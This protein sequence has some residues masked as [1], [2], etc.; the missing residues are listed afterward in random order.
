MKYE[1]K[2]GQIIIGNEQSI[3][4]LGLA[5]SEL[6]KSDLLNLCL[7]Q[8]HREVPFYKVFTGWILN[9]QIECFLLTNLF[10]Q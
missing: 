8:Q 5:H 4:S 2:K 9:S 1:T 7:G 6:T 3:F 10:H